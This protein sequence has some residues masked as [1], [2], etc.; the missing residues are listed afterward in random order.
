VTG[1]LHRETLNKPAE[2]V[3]DFF[4]KAGNLTRITPESIRFQMLSVSASIRTGTEIN[5]KILIR[6]ISV[7]WQTQITAFSLNVYFSDRQTK[8]P[9]SY[10]KHHHLFQ[11]PKRSRTLMTDNVFYHIPGRI[12]EPLLNK[13]PVRPKPEEISTTDIKK[14]SGFL[15]IKISRMHNNTAMQSYMLLEQTMEHS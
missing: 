3:F 10:R 15:T 13:F 5:Y 11:P 2:E 6:G 4:N 9:Y 7:P 8:V 12:V 14:V 1:S